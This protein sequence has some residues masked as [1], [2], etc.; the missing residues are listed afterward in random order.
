M[1]FLDGDDV[2]FLK[3]NLSTSLTEKFFAFHSVVISCIKE[4]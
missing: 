4:Y 3:E 1:S 2:L